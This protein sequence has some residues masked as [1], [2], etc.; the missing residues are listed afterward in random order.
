M[1]GKWSAQDRFL[2]LKQLIDCGVNY[3]V[4]FVMRLLSFSGDCFL[5]RFRD[6]WGISAAT[7]TA[8]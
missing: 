2:F 3:S 4:R 7:I 8:N 1:T 5:G 6:E